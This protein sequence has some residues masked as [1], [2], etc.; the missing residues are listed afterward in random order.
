[1]SD[2]QLSNCPTHVAIIMDGNGRWAKKRGL[3]RVAGHKKGAESVRKV[4]K[5]SAELGVKFLTL[6]SF[7]SENWKRPEDEVSALMGL[8]GRYLKSEIVE[9][10]SN[11]IRFRVIGDRE[12]LPENIQRLI[13]DS[14]RMTEQNSG[15]TLILALSYGARAEIAEAARKIAKSAKLGLIQPDAIDEDVFAAHLSTAGIPDPD[16]VIRSSGEKRISNFLLW[17]LAYSE[18]Y[19]TNTLWPN[20]D[21]KDLIEA[22]QE[23]NKRD[24]RYGAIAS[25]S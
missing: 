1:M 23:F 20:F 15:M 4:I 25:E 8:L 6:Y 24:R 7:S 11:N 9:L 22:F 3:P 5:A 14:E 12:R 10:H 19:F 16:L 18:F 2:T 13:S 17:Q 21:K